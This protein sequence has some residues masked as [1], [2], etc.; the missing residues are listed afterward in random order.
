MRFIFKYISGFVAAVL[1]C[2]CN[3]EAFIGP[4][5]EVQ[6]EHAAVAC[7]G[8]LLVK[9]CQ[10]DWDI[11]GKKRK[12]KK[13]MFCTFRFKFLYISF[14]RLY[15]KEKRTLVMQFDG[16]VPDLNRIMGTDLPN[17]EVPVI[18]NGKL[19]RDGIEI[20]LKANNIQEFPLPFSDDEQ[21]NIIVKPRGEYKRFQVYLVYYEYDLPYKMYI[22]NRESSRQRMYTGKI[23]YACP[24]KFYILKSNP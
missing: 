8:S 11:Y 12:R 15:K 7:G 6:N 24:Y 18:D 9:F 23:S 1:L 21:V 20:A 3:N 13:E 4:L 22:S 5:I 17:I 10:N 19:L 2:G 14:L 16:I